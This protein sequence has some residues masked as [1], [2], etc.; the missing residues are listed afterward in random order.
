MKWILK[1][2]GDAPFVITNFKDMVGMVLTL[3]G[4]QNMRTGCLMKN[5]GMVYVWIIEVES[6]KPIAVA[7]ESRSEGQR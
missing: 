2:Q 4:D 6:K 1:N 3:I 5:F 7:N